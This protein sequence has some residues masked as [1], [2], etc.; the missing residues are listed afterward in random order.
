M[1]FG[2]PGYLRSLLSDFQVDTTMRLRHSDDQY[3]LNEPRS[4]LTMGFRAFERCAPRLFNDLPQSVRLSE[5][6]AIFKKKLKSYLFAECYDMDDLSI[7][8]DHSV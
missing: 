3:R 6:C 8:T 4:N 5:N 7:K 2:K 1:K